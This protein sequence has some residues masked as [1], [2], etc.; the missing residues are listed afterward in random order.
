MALRSDSHW[1]MNYLAGNQK[2][3]PG[4]PAAFFGKGKKDEKII[5]KILKAVCV[6]KCF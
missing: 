5:L 1:Q 6:P 3:L 4:Y 2:R